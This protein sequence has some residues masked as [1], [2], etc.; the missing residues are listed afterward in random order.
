[1]GPSQPFRWQKHR[2]WSGTC[3]HAQFVSNGYKDSTFTGV[4]CSVSQIV[5]V[6]SSGQMWGTDRDTAHG[7]LF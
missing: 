3:S 7:E 1:M 4:D 5:Q 6:F 2:L